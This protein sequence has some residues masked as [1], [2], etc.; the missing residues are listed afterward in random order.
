MSEDKKVTKSIRIPPDLA[1]E[2][3]IQA[4]KESRT[5]ASLVNI[6][7]KKYLESQKVA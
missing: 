2:A 4:K 1:M 3:M 5:F 7:V 6:A